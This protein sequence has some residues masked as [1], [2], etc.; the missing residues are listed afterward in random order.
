MLKVLVNCGF[1]LLLVFEMSLLRLVASLRKL[2]D[3][4][5]ANGVG[6]AGDEVTEAV[7]PLSILQNN[8]DEFIVLL[9]TLPE[10][11]GIKKDISALHG[12]VTVMRSSLD[13]IASELKDLLEPGNDSREVA[14]IKAT[15]GLNDLA[16]MLENY[17]K[18]FDD[19]E[20]LASNMKDLAAKRAEHGDSKSKP[21][22]HKLRFKEPI[23][24]P[25]PET[26]TDEVE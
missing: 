11:T 3:S 26:S 10:K 14:K 15:S 16:S 4:T 25:K 22:R 9:Q 24:T 6:Y 2:S 19:V 23:K 12:A 21:V 17:S 7:T 1:S 18:E 5:P 20:E 13:S 8:T